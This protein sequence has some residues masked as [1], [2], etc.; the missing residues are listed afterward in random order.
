MG[1]NQTTMHTRKVQGIC[2]SVE[3]FQVKR[4]VINQLLKEAIQVAQN[5]YKT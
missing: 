5:K 1:L 4:E 3:D 2:E